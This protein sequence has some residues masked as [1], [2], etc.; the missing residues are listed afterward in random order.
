MLAIG[1]LDEGIS[2]VCFPGFLLHKP[3]FM[4]ALSTNATTQMSMK[5]YRQMAVG[6]PI[7]HVK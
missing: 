7:A 3:D 4:K 5:L 6:Q 1:H 2:E